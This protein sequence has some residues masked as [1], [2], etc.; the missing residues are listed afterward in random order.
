[1]VF[2]SCLVMAHLV[3]KHKASFKLLLASLAVSTHP[4][5][6]FAF[7]FSLGSSLNLSL[8]CWR[9]RV[10]FPVGS[11]N[12]YQFNLFQLN[13]LLGSSGP[14]PGTESRGGIAAGRNLP[15]WGPR[16]AAPRAGKLGNRTVSSVPQNRH[17]GSPRDHWSNLRSPESRGLLAPAERSLST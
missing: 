1:M 7:M 8:P 6:F 9:P 14:P 16:P 15:G 10:P 17:L 4:S 3:F 13:N 12:R 11:V 2:R 5:A